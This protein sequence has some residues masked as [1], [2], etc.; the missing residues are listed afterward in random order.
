MIGAASL[1]ARLENLSKLNGH[2][3]PCAL[4]TPD[5][6]E[7]KKV[8]GKLRPTMLWSCRGRRLS[9]PHYAECLDV[10]TLLERDQ[11]KTTVEF[12]PYDET[13]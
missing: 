11:V 12:I 4:R 7:A 8:C 2:S 1:H 13:D 6:E 3:P 5:H 9:G 10:L